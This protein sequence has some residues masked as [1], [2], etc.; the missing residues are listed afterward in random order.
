MENSCEANTANSSKHF[1]FLYH[2]N[3]DKKAKI[4]LT[5][6]KKIYDKFPET[7][8]FIKKAYSEECRKQNISVDEIF[9]SIN[10]N[11]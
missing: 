6:I 2:L 3:M 5:V 1:A 7:Q 4:A 10:N 9:F 11:C 8:A